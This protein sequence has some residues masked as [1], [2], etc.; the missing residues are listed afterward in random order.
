MNRTEVRCVSS[1]QDPL[2]SRS[3]QGG[4]RHVFDRSIRKLV[5]GAVLAALALAP[6]ATLV[7]AQETKPTLYKR[8]GGY[9]ALA[10][11]TDDFLA[12][13]AADPGL[14]KFFVGHSKD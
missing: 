2:H 4:G 8:L 1:L 10:A 7:S 3:N 5:I 11:V 9:D 14:G 13:L 12:R 6:A